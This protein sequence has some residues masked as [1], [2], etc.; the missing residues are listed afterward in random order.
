MRK[1]VICFT[2]FLV[3]LIVSGSMLMVEAR[4]N[5]I[6][7]T[8]DVY[9]LTC[10]INCTN[11]YGEGSTAGAGMDGTRN[12]IKVNTYDINQQFIGYAQNYSIADAKVRV[13]KGNPYLTRTYH[14]VANS[15][16]V[17]LLPAYEQIQQ[18]QGR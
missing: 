16:K 4:Q 17:Q 9:T 13:S 10:Y 3:G 1:K 6:T 7:K 8:Y 12:Y 2:I 14:A 18:A 11:N 15:E 5:T